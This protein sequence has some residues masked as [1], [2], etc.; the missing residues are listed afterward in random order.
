MESA[1]LKSWGIYLL[2]SAT[3]YVYPWQASGTE[4]MNAATSKRMA[5]Q[6]AIYIA[7]VP[8]RERVA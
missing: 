3:I 2:S 7:T 5:I 6:F 4:A 8:P 1:V